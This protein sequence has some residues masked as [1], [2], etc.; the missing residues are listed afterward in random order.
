MSSAST[1]EHD[2]GLYAAVG[3]F[4]DENVLLEAIAEIRHKGY[5]KLEAYTPFPIHGIDEALGSK[6]SKLGWFV[7]CCGI[8][9]ATGAATFI[10]FADAVDY[11]IIVGGKPL[12][13]FTFSIPI[14]FELMILLSA[15]GSL[16]G[17][18]GLNRLPQFYHPIFN[19][20]NSESITDDGFVLA[21]E[22]ADPQFDATECVRVLEEAGARHAEVVA[23]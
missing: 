19:Y 20:K 4:E 16:Y 17:M 1:K 9:G 18:L 10:W 12:F 15:F 2:T 6:E 8:L 11:P 22:A 21:I 5:S 13:A 3:Q 7:L 23:K 14:M